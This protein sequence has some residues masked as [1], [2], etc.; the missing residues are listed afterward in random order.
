VAASGLELRLGDF[1]EVGSLAR[2]LVK[3]DHRL[4]A[5]VRSA[6]EA[7]Q[8]CRDWIKTF[9]GD[10]LS[11]FG[12]GQ[13]DNLANLKA[14][15]CDCK[16]A[17]AEAN[18]AMKLAEAVLRRVREAD[19]LEVPSVAQAL[20]QHGCHLFLELLEREW[21][22]LG[23]GPEVKGRTLL[24]PDDAA[25]LGDVANWEP[26][27][28]GLHVVEILLQVAD[29]TNFP[30]GKVQALD[31]EPKHALRIRT[32]MDG[33]PSVWVVGDSDPPRKSSITKGNVKC[34]RGVIIHVIDRI[35]YMP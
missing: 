19:K 8:A 35:L 3:K 28:W 21:G 33:K 32:D 9:E 29:L 2:A 34:D 5:A 17:L 27:C 24:A 1:S 10:V 22:D 12:S 7:L 14:A 26:E 31:P 13:G 25:F 23:L 18:H 15:Q 16:E 20:K 11:A 4:A 6:E 30:G